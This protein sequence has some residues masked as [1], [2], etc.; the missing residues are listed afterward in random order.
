MKRKSMSRQ[1]GK[2]SN[3]LSVPLA[4]IGLLLVTYLF[5]ANMILKNMA[6]NALSDANGAEVNIAALS[7]SLFPFGLELEGVEVT[8][9]S[10]PTRN[11]IYIAS[12]IADVSLSALMQSKLHI[13]ELVIDELSFGTPRQYAGF[14]LTQTPSQGFKFP[15]VQDLPS[16]DEVLEN[17]PLKTTQAIVQAQG[18]YDKYE[19][20]LKKQAAALPSKE[21]IEAYKIQMQSLRETDYKDPAKLLEAKK[22][23][24]ELK[25]KIKSDL[26]NAKILK[27]TANQARAEL[28]ASAAQLKQAPQ[29]DY[30]LLKG[31]VAGEEA[32]IGQVTEHLFGD[33]AQLYTQGLLMAIE[34]LKQSS[35][36]TS[37][38]P[39]EDTSGL[40]NVWI[41]SANISVNLAD[42][43]IQSDWS[44]IT[45]NHEL[46]DQATQFA[47]KS[48]ATEEGKNLSLTGDFKILDGLVNSKQKWDIAGLALSAVEL[49]P[50]EAQQSLSAII[51]SAVLNS[52]GNLSI[53]ANELSGN[54]KFNFQK[55][56]LDAQGQTELTNSIAGIIENVD[57]LGLLT[58]FSGSLLSPSVGVSSNLDQEIMSAI[59]A[60]FKD[61]DNPAL[62]ELKQKLNAKVNAQ[63]SLSD[64]QLASVENVLAAVNGDTDSLNDLVKQELSNVVDEKKDELLNKLKDKL[65][66]P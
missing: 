63:L 13:E 18:V 17:T 45:E 36:K 43:L 34:M 9:S 52:T 39:E 21:Q 31:L 61:S 38:M 3:W 25:A 42:Q 24:D 48:I 62:N 11:K 55:L 59:S 19:A 29:D 56:V 47:L 14:V 66:K 65:F 28:S 15:T 44:D 35:T 58:D 27:E 7:H 20:P 51:E 40:P 53:V 46:I 30:A 49:V 6:E 57:Q 10:T 41:K 23:F 22:T 12:A 1:E 33:K 4:L 54:S 5:F 16:V 2:I 64:N 37:E 32:A 50:K 26:A 60:S 8:D